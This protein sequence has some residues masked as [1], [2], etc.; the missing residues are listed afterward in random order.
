[1][2][3]G[4]DKHLSK[5][6][7]QMADMKRF[8]TSLVIKE[9]QIKTTM[10]YYLKPVRM[11]S[12]INQQTTKGWRTENLCTLLVGLQISAATMKNSIQVPQKIKHRT[13]SWPS[14]STSGYISEES[15]NTNSKRYMHPNVH[16][17]IIYNSQITEATQVPFIDSR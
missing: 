17:N 10:R 15:Q 1:M 2:G 11:L 5:E 14:N 7:L 4:S 8:S 9:M 3:R 16:C 13:T 12:S 6:D